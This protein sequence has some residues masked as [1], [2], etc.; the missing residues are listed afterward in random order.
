VK[1]SSNGPSLNQWFLVALFGV[2]LLL[3]IGSVA[4]PRRRDP[5]T[6]IP[7][8]GSLIDLRGD[9]F[10]LLQNVSSKPY[11]GLGIH[12]DRA[13]SL[14]PYPQQ[15]GTIMYLTDS[16]WNAIALLREQWC[17]NQLL[18]PEPQANEPYY[19]FAV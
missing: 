13:A 14:F 12:L 19:D 17:T 9:R 18:F 10:L 6:R 3:A 4:N 1:T 8:P 7:S 15:L 11:Y 16:E 2:A 5:S